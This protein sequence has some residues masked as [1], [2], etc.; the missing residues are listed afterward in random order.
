MKTFVKIIGITLLIISGVYFIG[1]ETKSGYYQ[2]IRDEV[3]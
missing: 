1:K 2:V 3:K